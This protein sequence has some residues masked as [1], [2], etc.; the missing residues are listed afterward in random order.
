[1]TVVATEAPRI[2]NLVKYEDDLGRKGVTREE[3]VINVAAE[4]TLT[5]GSVLGK[6]TASGK[7]KPRDPAATTTGENV[8][9]AVLLFGA[10]SNGLFDQT[11]VTI[12]AATDT[13]VIVLKPAVGSYAVVADES[14]VFDVT[15]TSGQRTT[16]VGELNSLGIQTLTQA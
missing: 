9:A 4:T 16:A 8:S 12:P 1:M 14:L 15:H 5:L 13:T 3:V 7:Y 6:V 10:G 11:S 2:S